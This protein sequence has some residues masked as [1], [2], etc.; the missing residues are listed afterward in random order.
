MGAMG[1][2]KKDNDDV[3]V[4]KEHYDSAPE[5]EWQRLAGRYRIEY[6]INRRF[7][8]KYIK[9]GDRVLDCGG[10]PGRY[11]LWLSERGCDV[12]LFDLSDGNIEFAKK[13]AAERGLKIKALAGDARFVDTM[14]DGEF[15]H[16]LLMGPLYH[17][18]E[19]ADRVAAVE[20][21]LKV[22]KPGGTLSAAFISFYGALQYGLRDILPMIVDGDEEAQ[23]NGRR[24]F[25]EDYPIFMNM[26]EFA[27][28]GFTRI[29]CQTP[30]P[31]AEFMRRF[32]IEK[33]EYVGSEGILAPY[34][35]TIHR[36]PE[37]VYEKL[38]S[39]AEKL[40]TR[41]ELL[42]SSEHFLYIAKKL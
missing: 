42:S 1:S 40:N 23:L 9:P 28:D 8:E 33:L 25:E 18:T 27:G 14:V 3:K 38:I 7:L 4:V 6:D 26:T 12:T 22:L 2:P 24:M 20:S 41:E 34:M 39:L 17:L 19:E 10:G 16:V 29:F 32:P 35:N 13:R 15:D 31:V 30:G 21:C 5:T 11:S 37:D 36:A